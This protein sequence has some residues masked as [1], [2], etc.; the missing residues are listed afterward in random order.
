[1]N[2]RSCL[3]LVA[4]VAAA[5]GCAESPARRDA[6]HERISVELDKAARDRAKPAAPDTVSQ[7][8]LPPLVVEMPKVDSGRPIDQRFDLNVNNAPANQVF[9]AIVSGTRFSMIPESRSCTEH[10]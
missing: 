9:M 1:M 10:E 8:L 2:M 7:A 3:L 5:Y 4:F 6:T